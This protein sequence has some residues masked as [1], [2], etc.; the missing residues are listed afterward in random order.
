MSSSSLLFSEIYMSI[1]IYVEEEM[2]MKTHWTISQSP[3]LFALE[4]EFFYTTTGLSLSENYSNSWFRIAICPKLGNKFVNIATLMNGND[5][6]NGMWNGRLSR[7][8]FFVNV[9]WAIK[10]FCENT[11]DLLYNTYMYIHPI[12]THIVQ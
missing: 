2:K 11:K 5:F 6:Q 10:N 1:W 7:I 3:E 12:W 9:L 8:K 4:M